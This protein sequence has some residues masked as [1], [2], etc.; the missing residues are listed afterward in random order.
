M[1]RSKADVIVAQ[2]TKRYTAAGIDSAKAKARQLG[3]NAH[4]SKAHP[5]AAAMGSGGGAV[6]VRK[7]CGIAPPEDLIVRE[8]YRN[9][10]C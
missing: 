9:R 3:W 4:L 1:S 7:G 10:I 5:T 6:M 2:E 8:P